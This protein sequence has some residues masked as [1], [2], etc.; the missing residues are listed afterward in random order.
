MSR[1]LFTRET[2]NE[3]R[4]RYQMHRRRVRSFRGHNSVSFNQHAAQTCCMRPQHHCWLCLSLLLTSLQSSRETAQEHT[5][6]LVFSLATLRRASRDKQSHVSPVASWCLQTRRALPGRGNAVAG[7][8]SY[9]L[10]ATGRLA[11]VYCALSQSLL[12]SL[13]EWLQP[14]ALSASS[15]SSPCLITA[16]RFGLSRPHLRYPWNVRPSSAAATHRRS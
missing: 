2:D 3:T 9:Q 8:V 1:K 14:Q 10:G 7:D 4:R 13:I 5:A 6:L 16:Q 12:L 11:S 15:S